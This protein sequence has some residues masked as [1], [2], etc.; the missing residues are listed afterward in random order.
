M[1]TTLNH[2]SIR[3]YILRNVNKNNDD[4]QV[5]AWLHVLNILDLCSYS[6]PNNTPVVDIEKLSEAFSANLK[7]F[8][9]NDDLVKERRGAIVETIK[10]INKGLFNLSVV[11]QISK[12]TATRV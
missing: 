4:Q 3:N 11:F 5:Y 1:F 8:D 2:A 7:N 12:N 10:T 6:K 9:P